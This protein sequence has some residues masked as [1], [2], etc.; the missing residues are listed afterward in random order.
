LTQQ[1]EDIGNVRQAIEV[2]S[3]HQVEGNVSTKLPVARNTMLLSAGMAALYGMNQLSVAVATITFVAVTGLEG[4]VGLGPAIFLGTA[5]LAAFPAGRAMDHFGRVPVLAG[6]FGLGIVGCAL[7]GL[8]ASLLSVLAVVWGFALIGASMGTVKLSPAAAADMYPPERRARG[9]SLVLFGAV[10]GAVLGPLVFVPLFADEDAQGSHLMAPWLVAAGFMVAGLILVLNVRPDPKRIGVLLAERAQ[11]G[12]ARS[13]EKAAPLARILRRP[14]VVAAL[15]AAAA[16]YSVMVG[17][18]TLAGYV[19]VGHGHHQGAVFP[20]VSAHLIGM[21]GLTLVV[22]NV[23]D[24]VGRMRA[25]VGGLLLLGF[26]AL[27]VVW[28]VESVAAT[29]VALFGIGLGWNFSYVA[30]TAELAERTKPAERGRVLGFAELLSGLLGAALASLGGL[31]LVTVGLVGLGVAGLT[32]AAAPAVW[33]LCGASKATARDRPE[34]FGC[35]PTG[36]EEGGVT[37]R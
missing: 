28:A 29:S 27:S 26:S 35:R 33:I 1:E 18:M 6:G 11:R 14:G 34:P 17:I 8:G 16:S 36:L 3:S 31:A 30:A 37:G 2:S 4:F 19:L 5:A 23:I 7:T 21:F 24:R 9:I 32:L 15:L 13:L 10:F 25:L 22:G 20:V 12:N